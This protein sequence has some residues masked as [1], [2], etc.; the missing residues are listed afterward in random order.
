MST[1]RDVAIVSYARTGIACA[2][3]GTL[4]KIHGIPFAAHLLKSAVA[5]AGIESADIED[6]VVGC[7]LP[8]GATGGDDALQPGAARDAVRA[9][10][11]QSRCARLRAPVRHIPHSIF[12]VRSPRAWSPRKTSRDDERL[13]C[14]RHGYCGLR[15]AAVSRA[16]R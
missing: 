8:E 9:H 15:R 11:H 5:R 13:H 10:E 4:N 6:I 16:S 7:G 3:C 14:W 12:R 2:T 1:T